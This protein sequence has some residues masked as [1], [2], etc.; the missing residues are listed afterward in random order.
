VH[1]ELTHNDGI[2]RRFL[3]EARMIAKLRHPGIVAVHA[4]GSAE[5]LLYYVMDQVDGESLRERLDREGK[6]PV[7]EARR[8]ASDLAG[9]LDAAAKAG[10]VH[11]DVT[12]EHPARP[13]HGTAAPA[14]FGVP[15]PLQ[16]INPAEPTAGGGIAL[17]T[18]PES[19]RHR[20]R[21]GRA[22]TSITRSCVRDAE[23]VR[24]PSG[25]R[26]VVISTASPPPGSA[27]EAPARWAHRS[28]MP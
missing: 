27:G 12:G 4:A 23:R 8:I 20:V 25:P 19:G 28:R 11:R 22:A 2:V 14:D 10:L 9:A 7:A 5:G 15:V 16:A 18:P 3:A 13:D 21:G 17:G 24:R 26:R 6:L 1:P